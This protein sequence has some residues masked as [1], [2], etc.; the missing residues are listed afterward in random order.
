[1]KFSTKVWVKISREIAK[2]HAILHHYSQHLSVA[3]EDQDDAVKVEIIAA[4][5]QRYQTIS[6][7]SHL[8]HRGRYD[9]VGQVLLRGGR[10]FVLLHFSLQLALTETRISN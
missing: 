3:M 10:I 5:C 9:G 4:R 8:P 7:C 6:A 2:L 1:M